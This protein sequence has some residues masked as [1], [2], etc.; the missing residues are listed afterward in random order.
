MTAGFP[1]SRMPTTWYPELIVVVAGM[2]VSILTVPPGSRQQLAA[3]MLVSA[4]LLAAAALARRSPGTALGLTWLA[5]GAHLLAGHM[6][7]P[8]EILAIWIAYGIGRYGSFTT[9]IAA[10]VSVPLAALVVV[11]LG[12]AVDYELLG[13]LR[14]IIGRFSSPLARATVAV[15]LVLLPLLA[16]LG[17]GI[18]A[19]FAAA[20]EERQ[21]DLIEE[22][23]A[24]LAADDAAPSRAMCT[25]SWDTR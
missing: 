22:Q 9:V 4:C 25:T 13:T 23:Q 12:S 16:P 17:A 11:G 19:R 1:V 3:M 6:A 8:I 7:L 20:S 18:A 21:S 5:L 10:A 2:L 14:A 24:R 15:S